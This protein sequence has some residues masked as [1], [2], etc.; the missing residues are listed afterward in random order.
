MPKTNS[1]SQVKPAL[2]SD[3]QKNFSIFSIKRTIRYEMGIET[4]Y[5]ELKY[6]IG[7]TN[8]HSRKDES[9][10]QEIFASLIMYNL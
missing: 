7:L 2:V 1:R 5:R 6:A 3:F 8:F 9:I 4:S 10:K